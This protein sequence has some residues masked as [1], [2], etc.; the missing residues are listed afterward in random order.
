MALTAS[1]AYFQLTRTVTTFVGA[2]FFTCD[3]FADVSDVLNEAYDF[4][5]NAHQLI[6]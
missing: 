4:F 1:C 2:P 3:S 6:H 5:V